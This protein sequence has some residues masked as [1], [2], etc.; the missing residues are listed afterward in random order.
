MPN[1][2]VL[3]DSNETLHLFAQLAAL[4]LNVDRVFI[5]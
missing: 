3:G 2:L 1:S 5:R 4:R